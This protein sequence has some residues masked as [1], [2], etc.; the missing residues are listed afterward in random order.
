[1]DYTQ[2]VLQYGAHL[3]RQFTRNAENTGNT[4]LILLQTINQK[5]QRWKCWKSFFA[6][7]PNFGKNMEYLKAKW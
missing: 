6:I 2:L 5:K 3:T 4:F 7:T 1:M